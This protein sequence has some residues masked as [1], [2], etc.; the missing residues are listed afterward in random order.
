[1]IMAKESDKIIKKLDG[2]N[3]DIDLVTD[4]R[5]SIGNKIS[6]LGML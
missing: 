3:M 2:A 6:V 1:M 5:K 4:L